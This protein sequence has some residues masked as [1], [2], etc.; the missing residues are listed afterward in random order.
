VAHPPQEFTQL[1]N[2]ENV[3]EA[4]LSP[5]GKYIAS[6]VDE[7]G[8]QS[9]QVRQTNTS[10]NLKVVSAK[11]EELGGLTFSP[12]SDKVYYLEY[13][14]ENVTLYSISVLGGA[15]KKLNEGLGTPVTFS[16]DGSRMAYIRATIGATSMLTSNSD[17]TDEKT[18]VV[19][20]EPETFLINREYSTGPAWSH[21]GKMIA[22]PTF[23]ERE[24]SK[25]DEMI[26][27]L[28]DGSVKRANKQKG[29]FARVRKSVWLPESDGLIMTA[30][31]KQTA[32]HQ[33]WFLSLS[34]GEARNITN[35]AEDY[36]GLSGTR[37]SRTL[38]TTKV[39]LVTSLWVIDRESRLSQIPSTN[40]VGVR[41]FSWNKDGQLLYVRTVGNSF[42]L[43]LMNS[44]GTA[45]KQVTFDGQ[46]N[47]SPK[48]SPDGRYIIFTSY[49][50]GIAHI[51]RVRT[52]GT[53]MRQLTTGTF[54]DMPA[55][56][57]DGKWMVFHRQ[58]PSGLWKVSVEGGDPVHITNDYMASFPE[59][60][61][62]GKLIAYI[63]RN[64]KSNSGWQL[65][66]IPADGGPITKSFD[67]PVG[68]NFSLPDIH[69]TFDGLKITYTISVN[70]ISNIWGQ[71]IIGGPPVQMTSFVE[72]QIF[73]FGWSSD[74]RLAC[75]RGAKTKEL[76]L[77][78][79]VSSGD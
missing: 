43:M 46:R 52:D 68:Y 60:S 69:F 6:V 10:A 78:K 65:V 79:N 51:W 50:E 33:L 70:G 57:P 9:L 37:D 20:K 49:R 15:P 8:L 47:Q 45:R 31:D 24:P 41:G 7:A 12:D 64:D 32:P 28:A 3:I 58:D 63:T 29:F 2:E 74:G 21:D 17:G 53:D 30:K 27:Q 62:D 11:Q 13:R 5:D 25:A 35:D 61:P 39:T 72:G 54:E 59:Y 75:V 38:L 56:S 40:N 55:L 73:N 42:D 1:P 22:A 48:A 26:V 76:F 71:P 14:E 34:T 18:L 66:I 77:I 23:D 67:V 19:L 4:V 36:V 16:P 44:D